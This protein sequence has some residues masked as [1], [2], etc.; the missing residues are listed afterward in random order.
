MNFL[1]FPTRLA[2]PLNIERAITQFVT[3][4]AKKKKKEEE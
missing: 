2:G 1:F 4:S 3:V